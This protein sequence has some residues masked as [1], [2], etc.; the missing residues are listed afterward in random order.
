[1]PFVLFLITLPSAH[2]EIKTQTIDYQQGGVTLEGYLAYDDSI[3]GKRPGVLICHEWWGLTDYPKHRA[4]QLAKLGYVAF[5]LDM[6]GKGVSTDDP[7]Q[8]GQL[9]RPIEAD[10]GLV[11]ARALAGLD[12]LRSQ[13]QC[14][15]ARV[16][17]IGYCF[18]G[19]V[20]L[21]LARSGTDLS[22]VVSFHGALATPHP[23]QDQPIK[24]KILVCTGADDAFVPP[25]QVQGFIDEMRKA[26]A[27]YQVI[28]YGG[29]HHAFTNPDA[30]KFGISNIAYN[31]AADHRSWAAMLS[32]FDEVFK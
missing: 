27:D 19:M 15:P 22:A 8:A 29:A 1:M 23:D 16:A 6:Y 25:Q 2:A 28:I 24:A 32:L 3:P 20:A 31:A 10:R 18:G 17:A 9:M 7:Q 11:R 5:A 14:D 26:G 21:E 13:P 12:V 30:D 4:E